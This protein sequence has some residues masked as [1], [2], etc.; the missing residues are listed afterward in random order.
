M[1]RH[2]MFHV[3]GGVLALSV[4]MGIGRFAYT[5]MLPFMQKA[6]HFSD[7]ISGYLASSNYAGYL[8]GA[9]LAGIFSWQGKRTVFLRL[10]LSVSVLS[11]ACMG[12]TDSVPVWFVLRFLSGLVSAFVFVLSSSIVLDVLASRGKMVW[13]GILYGGVGLGIMA[14]GLLV[15]I[16][17][18]L[19]SWEGVWVALAVMGVAGT[20]LPWIW[21]K[22]EAPSEAPTQTNNQT[23][24]LPSS[25]WLPW[26]IA[27]YGLEGLGY[28]VTGTFIVAITDQ[29]PAFA[30]HAVWVWTLVGLAAAPSCILWAALAKRR[31]Y[32]RMLIVSMFLQAVGI[33]L[34]AVWPTPL[35]SSISAVLFGATFMGIT[36]MATTLTR[37]ISPTQSSRMIGILTAVYGLGQMLGPTGAG[38]L[39]SLT[40]NYN[41]ALWGA[42]GVVLLGACF[43]GT[44]ISY[45]QKEKR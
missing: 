29:I 13:S 2:P 1:T 9:V 23:S 16:G 19:W 24:P 22:E 36:S 34:P 8:L 45:E 14:S 21:V 40:H 31:G 15:T 20:V 5:P 35:G 27:A 43:L 30:G 39:A 17:S 4:A 6:V 3:L 41:G 44:G 37:Q 42:A 25:K 38:L 32:V 26:L 33:V 12:L 7:A 18:T 28:I 10:S 11:T